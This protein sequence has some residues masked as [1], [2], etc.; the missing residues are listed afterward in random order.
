MNQLNSEIDLIEEQ[1]L[2]IEAEIKRHEELGQMTEK[3]KEMVR[4]KL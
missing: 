1:N 3:E 4:E 2:S